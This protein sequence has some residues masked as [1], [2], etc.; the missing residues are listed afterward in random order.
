MGKEAGLAEK[1]CWD[2][3]YKIL[4]CPAPDTSLSS[5]IQTPRKADKQKHSKKKVAKKGSMP[6][7]GLD[8]KVKTWEG[9]EVSQPSPQSDLPLDQWTCHRPGDDTMPATAERVEWAGGLVLCR[10]TRH[11]PLITFE[12]ELEAQRE[13]CQ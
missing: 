5:G 3:S 8:P 2:S 7:K 13:A 1:P 6:N 4:K 10:D 12:T 9:S 11:F